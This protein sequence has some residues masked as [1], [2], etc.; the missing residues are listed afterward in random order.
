MNRFFK[1][2][3]AVAIFSFCSISALF[4]Q[5]DFTKYVD[6]TIGNVAHFLVPTYPTIQLPNQMMRMF[7]VKKDYIADRVDAFPL[8]VVTHRSAGIMQ[9]KVGLGEISDQM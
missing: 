9:L 1:K 4:A 5:E 2:F 6:P 7:P 3:L 8:Q